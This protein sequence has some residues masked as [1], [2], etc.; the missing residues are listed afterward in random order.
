MNKINKM[1]EKLIRRN[2]T[3]IGEDI[4]YVPCIITEENKQE[5][6]KIR[7][8]FLSLTETLL[9]EEF[10]LVIQTVDK[11]TD[12]FGKTYTNIKTMKIKKI[13]IDKIDISNSC[14]QYLSNI[15]DN[16]N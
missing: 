10:Y 16:I 14:Q 11:M 9:P 12:M 7:S 2:Y 1:Q 6:F 5:N 13:F 3:K 15:S 8:G 4:L